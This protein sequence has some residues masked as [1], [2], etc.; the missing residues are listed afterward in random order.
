MLI[1]L[2]VANS[3]KIANHLN[4]SDAV[5]IDSLKINSLVSKKGLAIDKVS[6]TIDTESLDTLNESFFYLSYNTPI[7]LFIDDLLILD[8]FISTVNVSSKAVVSFQ[9]ADKMEYFLRQSFVPSIAS[10]CQNQIYS[11]FC[12]LRALDFH[13]LATQVEINCLTGFFY[14]RI[15]GFKLFIGQ[16][17]YDFEP[18]DGNLHLYDGNSQLYGNLDIP[19][20]LFKNP[21]NWIGM[22]VIINGKYKATVTSY[23]ENKFFLSL[24]YLDKRIIADTLDF[25]MPCDKTYGTCAVRFN[26]TNNFWGFPNTGL[27][28]KTYSIFSADSL[29]YCGSEEAE[30]PQEDCPLD[31]SLF[32][33]EI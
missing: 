6:F 29:E 10:V 13:L 17:E 5:Y 30:L 27:K 15:D 26:N 19:N 23:T 33:V 3:Y 24:N 11:K 20:N 18:I 14:Y 1:T 25:Y 28:L 12:G 9:I 22:I 8:G 31:H 32:G 2:L 16:N 4:N 7:K 21:D